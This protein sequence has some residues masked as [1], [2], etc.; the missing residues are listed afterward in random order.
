MDGGADEAGAAKP[1]SAGGGG[2]GADAAAGLDEEPLKISL[3]SC[4]FKLN[5]CYNFF[6]HQSKIANNHINNANLKITWCK[7]F[8][9]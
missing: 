1:L 9:I 7:F 3:F 8:L 2:G 4:M 6:T 5:N